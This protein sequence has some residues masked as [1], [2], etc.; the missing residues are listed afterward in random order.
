MSVTNGYDSESGGYGTEDAIEAPNAADN[1]GACPP[2]TLF[3]RIYPEIDFN[4]EFGNPPAT[5]IT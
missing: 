3:Y 2:S 4:N 5:V 1:G